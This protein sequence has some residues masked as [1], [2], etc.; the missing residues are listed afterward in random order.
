[1]SDL[2]RRV[3]DAYTNARNPYTYRRAVARRGTEVLHAGKVLDFLSDLQAVNMG[4]VA[5][6]DRRVLGR[7]L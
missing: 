3:A 1:M 5:R 4:I 2:D 7:N 6:T